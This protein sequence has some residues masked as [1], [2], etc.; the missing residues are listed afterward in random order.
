VGYKHVRIQTKLLFSYLI[1]ILF[2]VSV[3]G[4]LSYRIS[5]NEVV[6]NTEGFSHALIEQLAVNVPTRAKNFEQS[7]Y[8]IQNNNEFLGLLASASANASEQELYLNQ[9]K[10]QPYL[11]HFLGLSREIRSVIVQSSSGTLYWSDESNPDRTGG[12][13]SESAAR[14]RMAWA[15][16]QMESREGLQSLWLPAQEPGL[17]VFTRKLIHTA[18]LESVGQIVFTLES[19]FLETVPISENGLSGSVAIL[20]RFEA[21]LRADEEMKP[22][23]ASWL[24]E[25]ERG[26][27]RNQAILS[28]AGERY[29]VFHQYAA[30]RQWGLMFI[31]PLSEL[32]RA[33]D[34]LRFYLI[35]TS[36]LSLVI[37]VLIAIG[38]SRQV[39]GNIR[40]LERTMRRVEDGE[41][42]VQVH[43][44]SRDE[45]GL[46][47][48]RFNAMVARINELIQNLY[49]E[50][51]AKQQA[52]FQVLKAQIHPHFLY[53]TLGSILWLARM[54]KQDNIAMM[55]K[56]L[57]DLLKA[58][59]S[60]TSEYITV[61]E[62]FDYIDNYLSIQKFRF[63]NRFRVQYELDETI[64]W[65]RML[66][67]ILQPLVENA[68][69]HGI[70]MSKGDG[71]ITIRAFPAGERLILEVED[72]GI[73]MTADQ[74]RA[75][76][77]EDRGDKNYPGLHSIGVYN[78]NARIKLYCGEGDEDG[79]AYGLQYRSEPGQG[80]LV[81]IVLPLLLPEVDTHAE[82][83]DR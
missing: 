23:I 13:L 78:V 75:L 65:H 20:N 8:A 12:S 66:N 82:R 72:N 49:V 9:I 31:V 30:N 3:V 11:S 80:T 62:E 64:R 48:I 61:Q 44:T 54:H 76:L 50:R 5:T 52:E 6:A 21:V 27:S 53:N 22:V 39:T 10:I 25:Q 45:I 15:L 68:L 38:I 37:T 32:F 69:L 26:G 29:L 42:T 41:F 4:L 19:T 18:T 79:A 34:Q 57:I 67:F 56:S 81:T 47:G 55:T 77:S 7:T 1:V 60:R 73:G 36:A 43:P 70:E 63:E 33:S 46:L 71:T 28:H 14:G 2:T 74:T 83:N 51:M 24:A 40:K 16:E 35:M 59:V 58:S 17:I